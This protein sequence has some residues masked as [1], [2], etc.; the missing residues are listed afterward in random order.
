MQACGCVV[1]H[2]VTSPRGLSSGQF[3]G[4]RPACKSRAPLAVII[5]MRK[6]Y[7]ILVIC[8][9]LSGCSQ[10]YLKTILEFKEEGN[11]K[12][13]VQDYLFPPGGDG[14]IVYY[15][16]STNQEIKYC[17]RNDVYDNDKGMINMLPDKEVRTVKD[18]K[19]LY[20][21]KYS[22]VLDTTKTNCQ[23]RLNKTDSLIL[24]KILPLIKF[25]SMSPDKT[26]NLISRIIGYNELNTVISSRKHKNNKSFFKTK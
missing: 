16:D 7:Y 17:F 6:L 22:A 10:L 2:C 13:T 3:L 20:S 26:D 19:I 24:Y 15:T 11:C 12:I 1:G 4:R 18:N 5:D 14:L 23:N 25:K 9:V 8:F 21:T